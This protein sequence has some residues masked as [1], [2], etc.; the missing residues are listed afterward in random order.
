LAACKKCDEGAK[1]SHGRLKNFRFYE[2]C[3]D[4]KWRKKE[5]PEHHLFWCVFLL[6]PIFI[7]YAHAYL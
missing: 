6:S 2:V 4:G 1:R 5:C 7:N 3:S